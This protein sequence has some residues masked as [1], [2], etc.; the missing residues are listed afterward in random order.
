MDPLSLRAVRAALF[1]FF[2]FF[3]AIFIPAWT[4]DYWQGWAFFLT[5]GILASL[6]TIYIALHDKKLLESRLKMGPGAEKTSTQKTITALG[7]PVFVAG[8]V[9]M[10]F[11]HRFGWSAAVPGLVSIL[12]DGLAALGILIYFLVVQENRYAAATVDVVQGQ[13][14]ISTG[15]Y[16]LVRHP[17]YTGAILVL[18][19]M[20]IAL[21]SWWG[22]LFELLFIGGFAWRLLHEETVLSEKLPGYA[23]YMHKVRY[24]LVPYVW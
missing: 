16:A 11:D 14:V 6:A 12:G 20:P 21:G 23:E 1:G 15:P 18:A 9:I 7:A 24:H 3:A 2:W 13:T 17:M 4:L 10:V 5:L 22:L 8:I 19:G